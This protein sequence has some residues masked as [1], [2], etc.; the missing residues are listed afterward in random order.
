VAS[1]D[2]S[3]HVPAIAFAPDDAAAIQSDG[4]LIVAR[5]V[6]VRVAAQFAGTVPERI[7]NEQDVPFVDS[8]VSSRALRVATL[9]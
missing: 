6:P 5:T 4:R 1:A 2:K 3:C 7:S 8:I 9:N